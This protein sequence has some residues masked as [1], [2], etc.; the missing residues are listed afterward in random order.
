MIFH[1]SI[2]E[3]ADS[4]RLLVFYGQISAELRLAF[5]LLNDPRLLHLPF[6][7]MNASILRCV[8]EGR[9]GDATIMLDAYLVQSE[10]TV[11]A[12]YERSMKR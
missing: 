12:A 5:G 10:R 9:A 11:L 1:K 3:L 7:D 6:L 4:P 2:V 8:E